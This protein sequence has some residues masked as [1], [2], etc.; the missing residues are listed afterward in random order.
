M[1]LDTVLIAIFSAAIFFG[2]LSGVFAFA[3]ARKTECYE[4]CKGHIISV[5]PKMNRHDRKVMVD[6][7]YL[8]YSEIESGTL[9]MKPRSAVL[10]KTVSLLVDEITGEIKFNPEYAACAMASGIISAELS[11]IGLFIYAVLGAL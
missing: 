9:M 11:V 2:L 10:G 4:T 6:V 3:D 8:L 5:A 1:N 7:N